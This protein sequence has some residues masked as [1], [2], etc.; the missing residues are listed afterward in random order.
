MLLTTGHLRTQFLTPWLNSCR[1]SGKNSHTKHQDQSGYKVLY[2]KMLRNLFQIFYQKYEG[3]SN[4]MMIFANSCILRT[5]KNSIE[6]RIKNTT[7]SRPR[8]L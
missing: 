1:G 8:R 2:Q 6:I 4:F 3:K 5:L 7:Q